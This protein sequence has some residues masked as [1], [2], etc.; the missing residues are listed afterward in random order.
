MSVLHFVLPFLVLLGIL[1]FVHELGHFLV[2]KSLGIRVLKF[3][4]GFGPRVLGWTRG[5]TEYLLSAVPLGGYV[6]LYGEDPDERLPEGEGA[7]SFSARPVWHRLATVVAG[8]LM[9]FVLAVGLFAGL[10]AAGVPLEQLAAETPEAVVGEVSPGMPAEAAGLKGGDVVVAV[11]GRGVTSWEEMAAAI[12]GSGGRRVVLTVRRGGDKLSIPLTPVTKDVGEGQPRPVIGIVRGGFSE[13]TGKG[14]AWRA[15][16]N[17][18]LATASWTRKTAEVLGEMIVGRAS[19]KNLGGPI[20]IA[21]MAGETAKQGAL[22]FLFLMAVLSVNLGTLNLFPLPI[23]DGGHVLFFLVEAVRGRPVSVKHR[24][25]AQQFGLLVLLL[26]MAFVFYN[27]IVRL[28][29]G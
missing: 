18:V 21:K 26:L 13:A 22:S 23:L 12:A 7:R 16:W 10:N 2:A 3:S 28:V 20:A 15:P 1:V 19:P 14:A 29:S 6:K 27:D 17:G 11:D 25:A 5:E 9:N 24:E 4:L 8:P